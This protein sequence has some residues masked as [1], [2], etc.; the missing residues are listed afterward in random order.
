MGVIYISHGKIPCSPHTK[1]VQEEKRRVVLPFFLLLIR[2]CFP[3]V[4]N[5]LPLQNPHC[6]SMV[7]KPA[8]AP[9]C[10]PN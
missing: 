5:L 9:W 7:D 6:V 1:S 10:S 8:E 3:V 2:K 4:I